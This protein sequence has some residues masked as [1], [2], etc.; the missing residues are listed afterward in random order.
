[1]KRPLA[2]ATVIALLTSGC[3]LSSKYWAIQT[4]ARGPRS[5]IAGA[6]DLVH[7]ENPGMAFSL[8]R[9][10]PAGVRMWLL[11]GAAVVAIIIGLVAVA[12]RPMGRLGTIGVGLIMGGALGNFL[13]R[14]HNGTV[15]DFLHVHR[16]SFD[17]PAFNVA[18]MAVTCGA[19]LML[20]GLSRASQAQLAGGPKAAPS[21]TT[22]GGPQGTPSNTTGSETD[23][24]S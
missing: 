17:W 14:A 9:T 12:K 23:T 4:T 10:W 13:D 7:W 20:I 19:F 24:P 15:T 1:M 3:D 22:A 8:M 5:I 21:N 11:G 6:L 16:G 18:D 2:L